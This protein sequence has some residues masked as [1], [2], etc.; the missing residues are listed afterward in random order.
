MPGLI[1][2][3]C[4]LSTAGED[5][6]DTSEPH[7]NYGITQPAEGT[8]REDMQSIG[9]SLH[10]RAQKKTEEPSGMSKRLSKMDELRCSRLICK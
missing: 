7:V 3:L 5:A 10:L 2:L 4:L 9:T 1:L 8:D 6:S